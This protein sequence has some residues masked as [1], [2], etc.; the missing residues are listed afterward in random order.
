M[1]RIIS[2]ANRDLW[3]DPMDRGIEDTEM[4]NL[5]TMRLVE[6]RIRCINGRFS[7]ALARYPF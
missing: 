1:D 6:E 5:L 2:R 3:A 7:F 4:L